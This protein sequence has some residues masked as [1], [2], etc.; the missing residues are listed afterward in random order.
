[1]NLYD[2]GRS[3]AT[4]DNRSRDGVFDLAQLAGINRIWQFLDALQGVREP[5]RLPAILSAQLASFVAHDGLRYRSPAPDVDIV[6]GQRA[7]HR[8]EFRLK[9]EG[10]PVGDVL[11]YRS[12]RFSAQEVR[13]LEALLSLTHQSLLSA[14]QSKQAHRIGGCCPVTGLRNR[15]VLRENLDR[16]LHM[17]RKGDGR[18]AV[19]CLDIDRFSIVNERYGHRAGD[20]I[21]RRVSD[22]LSL[23]E[24]TAEH[25]FRDDGDGFALLMR[26]ADV[27]VVSQRVASW[28]RCIE[29]CPIEFEGFAISVTLSAGVAIAGAYANAA[30][31]LDAAS[32]ALS[33]A[34]SAGRNRLQL[35]APV[36]V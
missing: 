28:L 29:T 18:I 11:I 31:M 34:K 9:L 16:A 36:A 15:T 25:L 21:L 26:D 24:G 14:L 1:M 27:R 35:A 30:S 6:I 12:R 33:G 23:S 17:A 13:A 22:R 10:T 2:P 5:S 8:C 4:A 20:L 7:H 32:T 19:A 3:G